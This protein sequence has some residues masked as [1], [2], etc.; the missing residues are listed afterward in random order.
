MEL[1]PN[2]CASCRHHVLHH[3][4]AEVMKCVFCV[5]VQSTQRASHGS[6]EVISFTTM[7]L[8]K[9]CV[10]R[11]LGGLKVISGRMQCRRRMENML[12]FEVNVTFERCFTSLTGLGSREKTIVHLVRVAG[13]IWGRL[14]ERSL[15]MAIY[16][17]ISLP[18]AS[19]RR[20]SI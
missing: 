11:H 9:S 12:G 5:A 13:A 3:T 16:L 20:Q 8:G 4:A 14:Y 1:R 7:S 18:F 10:K 17:N 6:G 2:A 15:S 19:V